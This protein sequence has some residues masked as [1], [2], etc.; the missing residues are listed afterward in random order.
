M[1]NPEQIKKRRLQRNYAEMRRKHI[2]DII[3][4]ING[5]PQRF[6]I[7]Q[8]QGLENTPENELFRCKSRIGEA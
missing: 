1:L 5:Y 4:R 7:N 2:D 6:A 8:H 3:Y